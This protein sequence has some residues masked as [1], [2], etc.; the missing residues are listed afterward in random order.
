MPRHTFSDDE[1]L[2]ILDALL[3]YREFMNKNFDKKQFTNDVQHFG[4][5]LWGIL[6]DACIAFEN[7]TGEFLQDSAGRNYITAPDKARTLHYRPFHEKLGLGVIRF[8]FV[9]MF[10]LME[11]GRAIVA[12]KSPK[13]NTAR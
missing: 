13:T 9:G 2:K 3:S 1:I 8:A 6:K 11:K 10:G 5:N 12:L 7:V 4:G